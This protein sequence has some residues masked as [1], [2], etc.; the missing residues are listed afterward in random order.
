MKAAKN[1]Y[2]YFASSITTEKVFLLI[3]RKC[4][5]REKQKTHSEP[6]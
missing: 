1:F 3:L 6:S 2:A 5:C 4:A